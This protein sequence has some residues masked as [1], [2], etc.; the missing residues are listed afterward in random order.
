MCQVHAFQVD[1]VFVLSFLGAR[2]RREVQER[3]INLEA[4]LGNDK[5]DDLTFASVLQEVGDL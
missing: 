4:V 1:L 3:G 5:N 2:G